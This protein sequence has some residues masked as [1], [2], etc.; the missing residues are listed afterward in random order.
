MTVISSVC[1]NNTLTLTLRIERGELPRLLT[2]H[3]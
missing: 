2:R 1:E 3:T